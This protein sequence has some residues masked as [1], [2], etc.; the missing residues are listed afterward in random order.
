[1]KKKNKHSQPHMRR[2]SRVSLVAALFCG[3]AADFLYSTKVGSLSFVLVVGDVWA[4]G[5]LLFA[6]VSLAGLVGC[7]V[8]GKDKQSPIG[9]FSVGLSAVVYLLGVG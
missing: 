3:F 7:F 9:R 6:A 5:Q 1:M 4:A 2:L 8:D